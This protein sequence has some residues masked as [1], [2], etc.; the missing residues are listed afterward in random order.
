MEGTHW[1]EL[2]FVS[3]RNII[4]EPFRYSFLYFELSCGSSRYFILI[5]FLKA[6][7]FIIAEKNN[8]NKP[9]IYFFIEKR[10]R[11]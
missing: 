11:M 3:S 7:G 8:L 10:K 4:H 1:R 5:S 2:F 6:C 9:F